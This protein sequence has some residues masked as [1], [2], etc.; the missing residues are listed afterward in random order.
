VQGGVSNLARVLVR[1]GKLTAYQ[2]SALAQGKAKGL[3]VG[4]YLILDKLGTGGM[5]VVF[6]AS[7]RRDGRVVALKLLPPSFGRDRDAVLRFR[8]EFEV[9]ARLCHSNVVSALEAVEDRGVHCITM[10]YIEG[11]DLD[12]LVMAGGPLTVKQTLNCVTQAARGLEEAH[13]TGIIHRDIKPANLM[14]DSSGTVKLLDLGLARLV[15]SNSPFGQ[16]ART[17]LTQSRMYMGTVDYMAPEQADDPRKVDHRADIYSLG[18]TFFFLLT[19]RPPFEGDTTIKLIIAHHERPAPSLVAVRPTTPAAIDAVYEK[20]MAKRPSDR[21]QSATALIALLEACQTSADEEDEA[22]WGLRT[23]ADTVMKRAATRGPDREPSIFAPRREPEPIEFGTDLRLEDVITGYHPEAHPEPLTEDRLPPRT[24][25]PEPLLT[26]LRVRRARE[27]RILAGSVIGIIAVIAIGGVAVV[28]LLRDASHPSTTQVAQSKPNNVPK[29]EHHKVI[30][31]APGVD[32]AASPPE[33]RRP[34][35]GVIESE[36]SDNLKPGD[37]P[38]DELIAAGR[39]DPTQAPS[40]L[41]AIIGDSRFQHWGEVLSMAFSPDSKTLATGG[42]DGAA[43]L[44]DTTTGRMKRTISTGWGAVTVAF[45]ADGQLLATTRRPGWEIPQVWGAGTGRERSGP[46]P[47]NGKEWVYQFPQLA[48]SPDGKLLGFGGTKHKNVGPFPGVVGNEHHA[49]VMI[50]DRDT[51]Q[52]VACKADMLSGQVSRG[53]SLMV[54]GVCFDA[55][56]KTL[57]AQLEARGGFNRISSFRYGCWDVKTGKEVPLSLSVPVPEGRHRWGWDTDL[58]GSW[59]AAF[60]RESHS[61][62][63]CLPG[64]AQERW[65]IFDLTMRKTK[66]RLAASIDDGADYAEILALSPDG[67]TLCIAPNNPGSG[68]VFVDAATGEKHRPKEHLQLPGSWAGKQGVYSPDGTRIALRI[69]RRLRI[70]DVR[71]EKELFPRGPF[72]GGVASLAF[73]PDGKLLAIELAHGAGTYGHDTV[74]EGVLLWDIATRNVARYF[75]AQGPIAFSPTGGTVALRKNK[76]IVLYDVETSLEKIAFENSQPS[77]GSPSNNLYPPDAIAFSADGHSI[78]LGYQNGL[79]ERRDTASATVIRSYEGERQSVKSVAFS[80]D[81]QRIAASGFHGVSVWEASNG[82]LIRSLPQAHGPVC[83]SSDD[84][85]LATTIQGDRGWD[86]AIFAPGNDKPRLE[87]GCNEEKT[88]SSAF[89]P[90]G[91]TVATWGKD[92]VLRLWNATD[93]KELEAIRLCAS[94]GDV[95]QI[96]FSPTGRHLA[97]ANSNGTVYILRLKAR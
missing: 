51:G 49:A 56:S 67:K 63:F 31:P 4:D 62:L 37:I 36:A 23:F 21:P 74:G 2:A 29:Q 11:H 77:S 91:K 7:R 28:G 10:E 24:W 55:Q 52:S 83:F 34:V 44:W 20:M 71:S 26:R 47:V 72:Q 39:G 46:A 45:S 68:L 35:P 58:E 87:L 81:G 79:V 42:W 18:C 9:A 19:G 73:S 15:A 69:G 32:R 59:H 3:V 80:A 75:A 8:R 30:A 96:A 6:K 40:H 70:W 22:R 86:V 60:C 17:N 43:M 16:S 90:D 50:W 78:V 13:A 76:Q 27:S 88:V 84:G 93:G 82:K 89:S 85:S 5:G 25:T 57:F 54:S 97:T 95:N 92:G 64:A 1:A 14:L 48:F 61:L 66:G 53:A 33:T 94:N 38:R 65:E 41:V 12:R